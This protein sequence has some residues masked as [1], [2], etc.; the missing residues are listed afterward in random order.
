MAF[1]VATNQSYLIEIAPV[2][3]SDF[4]NLPAGR[5]FFNWD[6]EATFEIFKLTIKGKDDILGLISFERISKEMRIHVRLLIASVENVGAAKID[7]SLRPKTQIAQHYIDKY[8]IN[9]TGMTRSLEIPEIFELIEFY[10]HD[11]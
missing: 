5:Y 8:K 3:T 1:E 2:V 9:I 10:D 7:D 6:E 4:K 11:N